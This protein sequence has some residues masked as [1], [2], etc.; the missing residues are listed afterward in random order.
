MKKKKKKK[1][2][3]MKIKP[4]LVCFTIIKR[5]GNGLKCI[6]AQHSKKTFEFWKLDRKLPNDRGS[7]CQ[8]CNTFCR[9]LNK[10]SSFTCAYIL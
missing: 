9:V 4:K 1:H 8:W 6:L 7:S 10:I 2:W 5:Q 3:I